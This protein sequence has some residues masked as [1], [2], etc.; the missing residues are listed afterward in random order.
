M[1]SSDLKLSQLLESKGLKESDTAAA[2][3]IRA[4]KAA[5]PNPTNVETVANHIDHIVKLAGIDHVGLGSDYD[6]TG[7]SLPVGLEDVSTYPKL[8]YTL[9]KRGYTESDIEKICSGNLLRVW[10]E[11]IATSRKLQ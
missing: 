8:I 5:H 6:G 10:D 1:C 4:F 3:V 9:L 2:A 11:V 7:G